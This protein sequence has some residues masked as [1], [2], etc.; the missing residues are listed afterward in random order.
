MYVA[1]EA[2]KGSSFKHVLNAFIA[3]NVV[4]GVVIVGLFILVGVASDEGVQRDGAIA[5]TAFIGS[6]VFLMCLGIL[7]YG[8]SLYR[9]LSAST[10]DSDVAK[11]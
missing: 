9:V 11:R 1:T 7:V 5:G 3:T 2:G 4:L 6:V 8:I 10:K